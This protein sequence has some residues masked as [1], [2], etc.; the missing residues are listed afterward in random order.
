MINI[1]FKNI[2]EF[3]QAQNLPKPENPLFSIGHK[4]LN[5]D[6]IEKC[7]LSNEEV[8][9]TNQFYVISLKNIVSGEIIY[10]RTKYDSTT[11]TMLFMAPD[12]TITVTEPSE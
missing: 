11:G 3:N 4:E 5:A 7:N 9:F 8:S 6:E 2:S 10:G 12:Q 1:N